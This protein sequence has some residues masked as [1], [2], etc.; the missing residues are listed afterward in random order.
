MRHTPQPH[1]PATRPSHTPQED[2]GLT[3]SRPSP[4][5]TG[6]TTRRA[7]L[8][9]ST[10]ALA[11]R[12][13]RANEALSDSPTLLVAGP[14]GGRV[15]RWATQ[16]TAALTPALPAGTRLRP[17]QVGG[18]DGVTGANQFTTRVTP[19]GNTVLLIPGDAALAWLVG[20]PRARFDAAKWLGVAAGIAPAVVCGPEGL[21]TRAGL[22]PNT[23]LPPNNRIRVGMSGPI[24]PDLAALLGLE[25]AGFATTPVFGVLDQGTAAQAL[26]S[27]A[28]D[29]VLLRG[30]AIASNLGALSQIGVTPLF[31]LGAIAGE[32]HDALLHQT[33]SLPEFVAARGQTPA[34]DLLAAW[35]AIAAAAQTEY[36]LVLPQLTA[37]SL[38]ALWRQAGNQAA[39]SP[40]LRDETGRTRSVGT[41]LAQALTQAMAPDVPAIT[42]LRTWLATRLNWRPPG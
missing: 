40:D 23:G 26:A 25:L 4:P 6:H 12:T 35:R 17:T 38:V 22:P 29:A 10:A 32:G 16:L 8:A 33:P 18:E 31:T 24:S 1:A 28:A 2:A 21:S 39:A 27:R 42:A 11:A 37:A 7:I 14:A 5:Q 30:A 36:A 41:P 13:A 3:D 20:D 34:P 15:D 19:D 9:L